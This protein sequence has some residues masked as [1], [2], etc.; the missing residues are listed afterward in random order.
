M[1][2]CCILCHCNSIY[3]NFTFDHIAH[4]VMTSD[5]WRAYGGFMMTTMNDGGGYDRGNAAMSVSLADRRQDMIRRCTDAAKSAGTTILFGM[6]TSLVLQAVPVP[7][8]VA[9]TSVGDERLHT[10]SSSW[11]KRVRGSGLQAHVW[12]RL[13]ADS[14]IRIN[15]YVYALD[16]IHTWA[17]MSSRIAL[18]DL[19]ALADAVVTTLSRDRGT[20]DT[21]AHAIRNAM[22]EFV[23]NGERFLGKRNCIKALALCR[24]GVMSPMETLARLCLTTY[25]IPDPETNYVVPGVTFQ[26]G[27]EMTLDMAWPDVKVAVEYDGDQHRTDK[28]QWRRDQ[29][30]RELLRS[31]GWVVMVVTADNLCDDSARSLFAFMVGRYLATRGMHVNFRLTAMPL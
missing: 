21:D 13:T 15:Q 30:K 26:S 10:V 25:G 11:D 27:V 7:S 14:C 3:G 28:T 31:Q 12:K 6:T 29:E 8:G 9:S 4:P 24:T 16:L 5:D 23:N 19:V 18:V 22:I 2:L 20:P 1:R 17:Q